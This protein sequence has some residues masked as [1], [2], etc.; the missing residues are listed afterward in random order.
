MAHTLKR[1]P[2]WSVCRNFKEIAVPDVAI[3]PLWAER[4]RLLPDDYLAN[5]RLEVCL[6]AREIPELDAIFRRT[7]KGALHSILTVLGLA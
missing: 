4:G 7:R 2:G 1:A 3:L 5:S 6:Q